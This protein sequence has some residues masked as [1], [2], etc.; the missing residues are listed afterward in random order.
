MSSEWSR[1]VISG[2]FLPHRLPLHVARE[3]LHTRESFKLKDKAEFL[4]K[5]NALPMLHLMCSHY[6]SKCNTPAISSGN[7]STLSS[8]WV[9]IRLHP[10]E[11]LLNSLQVWPA[12]R[13]H[14]RR[15]SLWSRQAELQTHTP[16]CT[17][18]DRGKCRLAQEDEGTMT[19][20]LLWR[21][22]RSENYCIF[23][24][25]LNA[26]NMLSCPF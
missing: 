20:P 7:C 17:Q 21:F 11:W 25:V 1:W 19:V 4:T 8:R 24:H 3:Y 10:G 26:D 2:D 13:G 14:T 23:K 16:T 9:I 18:R 6:H 22:N 15:L 12:S 5:S